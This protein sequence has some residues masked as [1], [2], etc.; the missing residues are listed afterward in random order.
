VI[1]CF[2]IGCERERKSDVLKLAANGERSELRVRTFT[3]RIAVISTYRN[4][5][6]YEEFQDDEMETRELLV[7]R[8]DAS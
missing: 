7:V 3:T 4:E 1:I 6:K 2:T 8:W 5:E